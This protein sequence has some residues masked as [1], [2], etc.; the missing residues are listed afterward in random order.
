MEIRETD[1]RDP[2]EHT[3]LEDVYALF[4]GCTLIA[5]GLVLMKA[6]G[7]VT[8]GVAGIAL[9]LSY[10]MKLGVGPLFFLLNIPFFL[11]GMRVMGREFMV[12]TVLA[13]GLIFALASV[14]QASMHLSDVH[15]AFAALAG[16][17]CAGMG[18]LALIRHNTGVG[19]V[20]IIALWL[21]RSRGWNVGRLHMAFDGAILIAALLAIPPAKLGWSVLSMVAVNMI[22]VAYHRPGRY[23]GH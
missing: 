11:L 10:K 18:I 22:L 19:G 17:T 3:L 23:L 5:I 14:A 13:S 6:A 7:I 20:N 21:Q 8:A 4:T 2:H 15:P 9:L 12:K 1:L 16:G